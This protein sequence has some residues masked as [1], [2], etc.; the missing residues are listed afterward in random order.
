MPK[1]FFVLAAFALLLVNSP[2]GAQPSPAPAMATQPAGAMPMASANSNTMAAPKSGG[3]MAGP[4]HGAGSAVTVT[5]MP[6]NGSN[7]SGMATLAQTS[8]G[9]SV[10]LVMNVAP[11]QAQPAH[12]H[13]GTCSKLDPTPAYPLHNV[14]KGTDSQGNPKGTS[15]TV[16]TTVTLNKLTS[17][18]YAINVHK[19]V[20]DIK[21]YVSCGDIKLANPTGTSQ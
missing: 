21:T 7:E 4:M 1:R 14:T 18:T 15:T 8:K 16:L 10:T 6:Q 13:K 20:S 12:I 17:G 2:L 3:S 9:L 11:S 19:S 5:M